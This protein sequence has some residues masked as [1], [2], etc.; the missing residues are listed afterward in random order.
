MMA[1]AQPK[2]VVTPVLLL[3]VGLWL[4]VVPFAVTGLWAS[5]APTS[6]FASFPGLG[7]A[8][9]V[10]LPPYNEHLVRDVGDLYLGL[11][12]VVA[13]AAV[14]LDRRVTQ[15]ALVASLVA[16]LPHV[17]FHLQHL[18]G[19]AAADAT[20]ELSSLT[21]T[22]VLP[23]ALLVATGRI[24]GAQAQRAR[25]ERARRRDTDEA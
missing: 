12:V 18:D 5:L 20:A 16:G 14:T 11:A 4:L 8:W 17:L 3:R 2:P 19:L 6:F 15:A 21:L 22:V 9:V 23:L 1:P 13:W 10:V 24:G 25:C 7:H